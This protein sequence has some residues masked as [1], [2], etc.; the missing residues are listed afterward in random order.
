MSM[1]KKR[2]AV[3]P[4]AAPSQD[5]HKRAA[6][7][8]RVST[9][10]QAEHGYSLQTQVEACQRYAESHG[11]SVMAMFKDDYTGTKLA[12]PGLDQV[13]AMIGRQEVDAVIVNSSDRLS[14][15][16]AHLLI[17]REEWQR[18]KVELHFVNR[19]KS[20][21]TPESRMTENIEGVFNEYWREKIVE[22]SRRGLNG[23]AKAGKVVCAGYPPYG[24]AF[25]DGQLVIVEDEAAIVRMIYGFYTGQGGNRPMSLYAIAQRLSEMHVPTPGEI[26]KRPRRRAAGAWD[27][28]A[29]YRIIT[30]E[31]YAG[32]WHY[33][34]PERFAI[35]VPAIVTRVEW[36]AAQAQRAT[37][38]RMSRRN[39]K[40]DYLLSGMIECECSRAMIGHGDHRADRFYYRC[41]THDYLRWGEERTCI[42]KAVRADWLDVAAWEYI[43]EIFSDESQFEEE[44][45]QAQQI[46]LAELQP[47][48]KELDMTLDLIAQT[49]AEARQIAC[50]RKRVKKGGLMARTFAEKA[51]E[52]DRQYA[53]LCRHHDTLLA[54]L[55]AETLTD[56]DIV[57]LKQYRADVMLG[58]KVATFEDKRFYLDK[59][60]FKAVLNDAQATFV[61]RL[62][63]TPTPIGI[64]LLRVASSE[65]SRRGAT[66]DH[67]RNSQ[68]SDS[69]G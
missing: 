3:P 55:E 38:K 29:V 63:A 7:Y 16:L 34:E 52:L 28:T 5:E 53:D 46:E 43:L 25:A 26:K 33:G 67:L 58:L 9:D 22:A 42:T 30:S 32:V 54:E 36:E 48:R 8:A 65:G 37:N 59:L 51:E 15:K 17:L 19:G 39:A 45:K 20:E 10:E 1:S 66:A 35:P 64:A 47:K 24:Y 50:D 49:E 69:P 61:C 60:Q 18:A 4:E 40:H 68:P 56:Q 21:D 14:R 2:T 23:K 27:L 11:L 12:R 57:D 44:L 41:K 13:R 6:I 31:T 62:R